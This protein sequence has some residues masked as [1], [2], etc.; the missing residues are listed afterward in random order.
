MKDDLRQ[1]VFVVMSFDDQYFHLFSHIQAIAA[2]YGAYAVRADESS[3][4]IKKIRPGIFSKIRD[5]VLVV[6]EIS[7]GSPNVLYEI[8]WAHAMGKP[9]LLVAEED[10]DIPFDLNDYLVLKYDASMSPTML[11]RYL[12]AEFRKHLQEAEKTVNLR[13]PLVEVLGSIEDVASKDDLFTYLLG[14][15]IDRFAHESKRW[16]GHSINVGAAEAVEKGLKIFELLKKGGFATYLVPLHAF[17]TT[18]TQYLENCRLASQMRHAKIERVFIVPNHEALF[19]ASLRDHVQ[20]DESA[21]IRTYVTFVDNVPEKDAVQDFGIWDD[22]LLCLIDVGMVGAQPTVTGCTFTRDRAAMSRALLWKESIRSVAQPAVDLLEVIDRLERRDQLLLHSADIMMKDAHTFCHGSYLTKGVSSCEWYHSSWQYLRILGL[23]STPDWHSD[24]YARSFEEAFTSGV[25]DVLVSGTA[26]YAIIH[27]LAKAIPEELAASVVT[28][29]MDICW[30]PIQI[31]KWYDRWYEHEFGTR[32]NLRFSQRDA[33]ETEFRDETFDMITTD[34][35]ITRFEPEQRVDLVKEW[36]RILKPGGRVVTTARL[37][38]GARSHKVVASKA[39]VD[40]FVTRAL[41]NVEEKRPWL[42][43]MKNLISEL[44]Q[45]YA[46]KITSYP[47]SSEEH[48][49]GLFEGF[50]CTI[51]RQYTQ[52]EFEGTTEYA[53]IVAVKE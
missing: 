49:Y 43:P 38:P 17:W 10:A 30:T 40:D 22:E 18:D 41:Q 35:F 21:G 50:S 12:E 14:W 3:N 28:T 39:D 15:S 48:I 23:V 32:L 47:L 2:Q 5:A 53:R 26:D 6:G 7:S 4:V 36:R 13:Q 31:C 11:R 19:S 37:S 29:V 9:T 27:H 42:R 16:T 20:R 44:A 52:G 34:A 33:L 25:R 1:L 8:G 24:F 46:T 45:A 51:E